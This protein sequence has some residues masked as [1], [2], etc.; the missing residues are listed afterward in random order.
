MFVPW[1][2]RERLR[3]DVRWDAVLVHSFRLDGRVRQKVIGTI[4][5][6]R[7]GDFDRSNG[8]GGFSAVATLAAK[9]PEMSEEQFVLAFETMAALCE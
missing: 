8:V 1:Q 6:F 3:G 4:A 9:V 7:E 5:G 2:K